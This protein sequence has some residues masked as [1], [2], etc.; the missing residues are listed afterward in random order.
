MGTG[1]QKA[2]LSGA[3]LE[4]ADLWEADL[5]G[6][7]LRQANLQN[8]VLCQAELQDAVLWRANLQGAD[9]RETNLQ[10][11]DF[12]FAKIPDADFSR[13]VVDGKTLIW[14]CSVNRNTKFGGVGLGSA[15]ID[16]GTRQLLEY[17]IRKTN[18]EE[19]YKEHR[20][21]K[22]PVQWFWQLSN[23][24]LSTWRVIILFFLLAALFAALYANLA[25]LW[26]PGVIND[27]YPEPE[28]TQQL[29]WLDYVDYGLEVFIRPIYFSVVTMTTLGFGDMYARKGSWLGHVLLIVQ[30]ILGYVLLGAMITRFAIL[31]AAGG[32]AGTFSETKP[33]KT[34]KDEKTQS[35]SVG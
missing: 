21:L 28:I 17:N 24:G 4:N 11:T 7:G 25:Y 23:Y 13:A 16:A 33:Q 2:D 10:G 30:V 26:P 6:A 18:W 22:R 20:I 19:W 29:S 35:G 15:R 1:L 8:T 31:F 32:P 12:S 27:L 9:L 14:K 34:Q 3:C 5:Q